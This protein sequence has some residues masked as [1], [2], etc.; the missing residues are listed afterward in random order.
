MVQSYCVEFGSRLMTRQVSAVVEEEVEEDS[1]A[2][3]KKDGVNS[4][5]YREQ[6]RRVKDRN[7]RQFLTRWWWWKWMKVLQRGREKK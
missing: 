2:V 4:R 6:T 7:N 5:T 3:E 1:E